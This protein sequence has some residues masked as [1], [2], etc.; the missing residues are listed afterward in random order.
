MQGNL[1][2]WQSARSHRGN[3]SI[4]RSKWY[5]LEASSMWTVLDVP[6]IAGLVVFIPV[7]N[8]W[9]GCNVH[10]YMASYR[11]VRPER[12]TQYLHQEIFHCHAAEWCW[13]VG[14]RYAKKKFLNQ[15]VDIGGEYWKG[16]PLLISFLLSSTNRTVLQYKKCQVRDCTHIFML[17]WQLIWILLVDDVLMGTFCIM[18]FIWIP[19]DITGE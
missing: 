16:K 2:E 13:I 12:H 5:W 1:G 4:W 7:Q 9:A 18:N 17:W 10:R 6:V 8:F 3:L 15:G 14:S 19:V 11:W